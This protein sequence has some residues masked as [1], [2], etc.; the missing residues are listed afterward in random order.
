MTNKP[1]LIVLPRKLSSELIRKTARAIV[2]E[3]KTDNINIWRLCKLI[4]KELKL[5]L[6]KDTILSCLCIKGSH[7]FFESDTQKIYFA[8]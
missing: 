3:R 7:T 8:D 2:H 6:R 1:K 4:E 5:K